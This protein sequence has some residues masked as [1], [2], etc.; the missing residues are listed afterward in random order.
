MHEECV[1]NMGVKYFCTFALTMKGYTAYYICCMY[2]TSCGGSINFSIN[3]SLL[4]K[5][6][7]E[8][9]DV[10]QD[11]AVSQSFLLLTVH[12][13]KI[14]QLLTYHHSGYL[15]VCAFPGRP[16]VSCWSLF[17]PYF[18]MLCY[19]YY[20][21]FANLHVNNMSWKIKKLFI[22]RPQLFSE[23][24]VFMHMQCCSLIVRDV[25]TIRGPFVPEFRGQPM[26]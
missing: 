17:L 12:S 22:C 25:L 1:R 14:Y 21:V 2:L 9:T 13:V 10:L 20:M 15:N 7:M 3:L 6:I 11:K 16:E 4:F 24:F 18:H 5:M 19:K 26:K 23:L 8:Q